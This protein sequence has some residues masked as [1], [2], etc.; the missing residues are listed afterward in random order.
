MALRRT[1]RLDSFELWIYWRILRIPWIKNTTNKE[2]LRRMDKTKEVRFTVKKRK[3]KHLGHIMR[4][5]KYRLLQLILQGKEKEGR[6]GPGRRRI[7]RLQNLFQWFGMSSLE[8]F[9]QAADRAKI[10]IRIANVRRE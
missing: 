1:R 3:K 2:V 4:N 5:N 9:R 6:R 8:L 7:S 10:A